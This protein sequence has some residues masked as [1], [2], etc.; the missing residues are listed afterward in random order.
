MSYEFEVAGDTVWSPAL[1]VGLIY[2]GYVR[3]LE[4]VLGRPAGWTMVAG[5]TVR[6]EPEVF[7]HFVDGLL[8]AQASSNHPVLHA[9]LVPVLTVSLVLLDRAGRPWPADDPRLAPVA[10]Y[11][12]TARSMAR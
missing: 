10:D 12:E 5:D 8:D 1:R 11:R 4:S 9:H 7:G 2:D 6:I 3:V